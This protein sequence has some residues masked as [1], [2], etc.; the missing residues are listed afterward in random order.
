LDLKKEPLVLTVPPIPDRYYTFEFLD[1]YTNVFSYVGSRATGSSGGTYLITSPDWN[2]QVP[3]G[4][5]EIKA[6]T[7]LVWINNRILV[8]GPSDVPNV[9]EIQDQIGL[10]PLS[11]LQ[12]K[13]ASP[14]SSQPPSSSTSKE[15]PVKPQPAL[16]PASGIKVYDE[17]GQGICC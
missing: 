15:I 6:P 9:H 3:S 13:V 11:V 2:G 10:V 5:T 8:Y 16:I 14:V 4:M 1:A 12:G 7:N 17:I